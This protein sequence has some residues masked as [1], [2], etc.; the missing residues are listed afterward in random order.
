LDKGIGS[1][2][3]VRRGR[4]LVEEWVGGTWGMK[5]EDMVGKGSGMDP[6]DERSGTNVGDEGRGY[7]R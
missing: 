5:D 7:G 2:S 4:N 6:E 3:A 1:R